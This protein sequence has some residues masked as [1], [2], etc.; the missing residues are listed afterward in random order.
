[1]HYTKVVS[2]ETFFSRQPF[3]TREEEGREEGES[4]EAETVYFNSISSEC[5]GKLGEVGTATERGLRLRLYTVEEETEEI[6]GSQRKGNSS[7]VSM[8]VH[9]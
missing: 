7:N 5:P 4:R 8:T 9:R 2:T 1:M 3:E 6:Q